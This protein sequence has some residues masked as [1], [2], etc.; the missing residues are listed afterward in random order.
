MTEYQHY[1]AV[2][3]QEQGDEVV[4]K[5]ENNEVVGL[6]FNQCEIPEDIAIAILAALKSNE[7]VKEMKIDIQMNGART[8]DL[9][10]KFG[11]ALA[12]KLEKN[13]G[14]EALELSNCVFTDETGAAVAAALAKNAMLKRFSLYNCAELTDVTGDAIVTALGMNSNSTL[15]SLS[16]QMIKLHDTAG[17]AIAAMLENNI[18]LKKLWLSSCKFTDETGLAMAAALEKNTSL[19]NLLMICCDGLTD[20][21]GEA[22]LAALEK[23]KTLKELNVNGSRMDQS[24]ISNLAEKMTR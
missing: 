8:H 18:T 7:S 17:M 3:S 16:F 22:L 14:L 10:D 9:G 20:Q 24:L 11:L 15:E 1:Y 21:T 19:E 6:K 4:Q 12:E 2:L 23:N 13:T 5:L